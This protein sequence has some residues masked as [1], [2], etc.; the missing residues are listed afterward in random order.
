MSTS[1]QEFYNGFYIDKRVGNN[2]FSFDKRQNKRIYVAPLIEGSAADLAEGTEAA[3]SEM[4]EGREINKPGL[5]NFLFL[6][7]RKTF[8]FDNHN[9][10]FFFWAYAL[11]EKFIKSR[12]PLVHIDQHKDTREPPRYIN[13]D[14]RLREL[15]EYT[16]QELNVGN[17]IKPALKMKM[18]SELIM[19]D[20]KE[21]LAQAFPKEFILD[22]DMD[23]FS[24]DM[25]YI[26]YTFKFNTIRGLLKKAQMTTIATSPYFVE[27]REALKILR[28][29]LS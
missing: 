26:D 4:R 1:V 29:L 15:F 19:V 10:A 8:I 21:S 25:Q 18:F 12:L 5:K 3:F 9:H 6:P 24:K 11:K 27:Q 22:L 23:I 2:A 17:F 14:S 13:A 7:D 16:N 20:S 28:E